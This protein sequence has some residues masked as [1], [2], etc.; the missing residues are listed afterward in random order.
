MDIVKQ[1]RKAVRDA[2]I[3]PYAV[4][5]DTGLRVSVIQQWWAGGGLR[6]SSAERIA[7]AL[8]YRITLEPI[9]T[10]GVK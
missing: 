10:K 8:G 5:R 2:G 3:T 7:K 9:K 1:L 4:A 6:C